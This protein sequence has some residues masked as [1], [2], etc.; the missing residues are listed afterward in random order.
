[1]S[2]T[3]YQAAAGALLMQQQLDVLS[4]NLANI[5]TVG[6][7]EDRPRFDLPASNPS[8]S[9]STS[10]QST[11]VPELSPYSPP[12][13]FYV[14]FSSGDLQR[15][16]NPLDVAITGNGFFEVQTDNGPQYSRKGNFTVNKDGLLSTADGWPVMGQ[17]GEITVAGSHIQINADGD[18]YVD[19][20][21]VDRLKVVDFPKPY[22]LQKVGDTQFEPT[23][24]TANPQASTGYRISQGFLESSNVNSIRTMTEI[25]ETTRAFESYQ[26]VIQAADDATS[27]TVNTVG[28]SV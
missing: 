21:L 13:S 18:I 19:G 23:S 8:S 2:G 16:Q 9:Q 28:R 12:M 3:I 4:N 24:S 25:I 1:M 11:T 7:K 5:N 20:D 26:K 10:G 6:Y 15:T 17:G 27:K 14:D 22:A